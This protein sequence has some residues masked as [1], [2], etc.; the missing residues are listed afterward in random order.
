[1]ILDIFINI[2]N[3]IMERTA[4]AECGREVLAWADIIKIQ[5]EPSN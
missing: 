5:H 1:M 4:Q 2:W 3:D